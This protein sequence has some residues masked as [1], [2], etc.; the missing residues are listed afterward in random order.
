MLG[1]PALN[2]EAEEDDIFGL[3]T[4]RNATQFGIPAQSRDDQAEESEPEWDDDYDSTAI[5]PTSQ[6]ANI[7]FDDRNDPNRYTYSGVAPLDDE[8]DGDSTS[9]G[10]ISTTDATGIA[11]PSTVNAA[12][13]LDEDS[14][15]SRTAVASASVLPADVSGGFA[16]FNPPKDTGHEVGTL[17]GM[18]LNELEEKQAAE[19]AE[20]AEEDKRRSTQFALPAAQRDADE[21]SDRTAVA[22]AD[23]IASATAVA[24]ASVVASAVN[25]ATETTLDEDSEEGDSPTM[26]WNPA[27]DPGFTAN[28]GGEEIRKS[29]LEQLRAKK[30]LLKKPGRDTAQGIPSAPKPGAPSASRPADPRKQEPR[31]PISET[32]HA[33]DEQRTSS[34]SAEQLT[35]QVSATAVTD[36]A[37]QP[38]TPEAPAFQGRGLETPSSGVLK[39]PKRTNPPGSL[40][41]DDTGLL[42]KGSYSKSR[43][44]ITTDEP[45]ISDDRAKVPV[46]EGPVAGAVPGVVPPRPAAKAPDTIPEAPLPDFPDIPEVDGGLEE[47]SWKEEYSYDETGIVPAAL[48]GAAGRPAGPPSSPAPSTPPP[49]TPEFPD[50][51]ELPSGPPLSVKAEAAAATEE[52]VALPDTFQSSNSQVKPFTASSTGTKF[53]TG[54][55]DSSYPAERNTMGDA[56]PSSGGF[57]PQSGSFQAQKQKKGLEGMSATDLF[58][59]LP[60]KVN[61]A[62]P[63]VAPPPSGPITGALEPG[64]GVQNFDF[65]APGQMPAAFGQQQPPAP[66]FTEASG[67]HQ[68]PEM[69][70]A[71]EGV[72]KF[73]GRAQSFFGILAGFIMLASL[74]F[75]LQPFKVP[76]DTSIAIAM[77]AVAVAGLGSLVLSLFPVSPGLRGFAFGILCLAAFGGFGLLTVTGSVTNILVIVLL[78]AGSGLAF[79][80][81]I[82]PIIGKLVS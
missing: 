3:G 82:F 4:G 27:E 34:I 49:T 37:A 55:A 40:R 10:H 79:V 25:S 22:D 73:V 16:Q 77:A 67:F 48:Q 45:A 68:N 12:W 51:G 42:G 50:F 21:S 41:N 9:V 23:L 5:V 38:K 74:Y 72:T 44:E 14:E 47:K 32:P 75:A 28:F 18:S 57:Q 20:A 17:L 36:V 71:G 70:D 1:L 31:R 62:P 19:A 63:G 39:V 60:D 52:P 43:E 6:L 65:S 2:A 58:S 24:D 30:H 7:E 15:P 54:G 66:D 76:D 56:L 26:A 53:P 69:I 33:Q 64:A 80:A 11:H 35:S 8:D 29:K 46:T 59:N 78:L 13:G 81:A 61:T